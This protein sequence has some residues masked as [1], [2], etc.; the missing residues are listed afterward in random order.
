MLKIISLKKRYIKMN[1]DKQKWKL[2]RKWRMKM[3]AKSV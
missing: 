1:I 2:E 3:V